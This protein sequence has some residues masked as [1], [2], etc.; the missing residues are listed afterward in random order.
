M[1]KKPPIRSARARKPSGNRQPRTSTKL[2]SP[3][4]EA[5]TVFSKAIE[6]H[7]TGR[8]AEAEALYRQ[9]FKAQP[10]HFDSL[11]LLGVFCHQ[12]GD[13]AEAL[14]HIDAA[15][16]LNPN[17]AAAHNNRGN[18]LRRLNRHEEAIVCLD[19]A[20]A[21][22]PDYAEAF[23]NRGNALQE[24]SRLDEALASFDRAIALKSDFAEAFNNRG[25]ALARLARFEEAVASYDRAIVLQPHYSEAYNNRSKALAKLARIEEAIAGYDRAIALKPDYA[26]AFNS[27]GIALAELKRFDEALASF[28]NAL[29]LKPDYIDALNN[30]GNVLRE[31]KR[32]DEALVSFEQAIALKPD[33]AEAFHNRGSALVELKQFD[34]AVASY[35]RAIVL[36]PDYIDALNSRGVALRELKRSDDA[37]ASYDRAI[38]LKPD[39]ADAFSNRG[40]ALQDLKRL[41]EAIASYDRALALKPDHADAW[42]NRGNALQ[43]LRRLDEAIA[44][45]DRAIALKS[46]YAEAFYNRGIALAELKQFDAAVASYDRAIALKPDYGEAFS[47]RGG[48]LRVLKRPAEAVASYERAIALKPNQNYLEGAWLHTKMQ[49]CDWGNYEGDCAHLVS[50]VAG[51]VA[52][53]SP[54]EFLASVSDPAAERT[55]AELF[56]AD[57]YPSAAVPLWRGERYTHDRIRVAYLSADFLEHATAYLMAGLFEAH[58]RSRFET[59]AVSFGSDKN[60]STRQRLIRSFDRFIDVRTQSDQ[61]IAELVRS[62]EVDIAV[63]LKGFTQDARTGVFAKRPA[64]IQ[65]NYLGYPGTMGADFIDYIIADKIVLPLDQEASYTEKI[66]HLPDCYQV[67]DS[68][69]RIAERTPTRAEAGLP[70]RGFV[71]CCFNNNFKITPPMFDVWMRLLRAI[72]GSVLWLLEDNPKARENLCK[73]AAARDV[74]PVRLVFARRVKVEEHLARHRLADLFLDTLPYN[75]HTTASDALWAGL[76]IVTCSGKSFPGRVAVSLL[77]AVDL[78]ELVTHTLAD[79]EALAV[80][81]ATEPRLL[82]A[83]KEKLARNRLTAPLF[84]TERFRRHIEAAYTTM[85][86]IWQRREAPRSLSIE[87]DR[88]DQRGSDTR[89]TAA[90]VVSAR[91]NYSGCPLCDSRQMKLFA[92]GDCSRH[93][94]SRPELPAV[95]RWLRCEA[96]GH[97]FTEGYHTSDA[98]RV[99]FGKTS[100]NQKVGHDVERQRLVSA[101]IVEKVAR[102]VPD[103]CWLDVGFGNG[104]LI[105]TA[106]EWGY[107]AVGI[108]L[109]EDNVEAV[110]KLGFQAHCVEISQVDQAGQFSVVSMADV[111][112]HMPFP[113]VGLAA[114]HRLLR[115]G[116]ALFVSMPNRDSVVWRFLDQSKANPYWGEVEHYHNFGRVRLSR[117]LAEHGFKVVEYGVSERYRACME[118]IAI[119]ES[120]S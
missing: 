62:L 58:D 87:A 23:N 92:Q 18:A 17:A 68:K 40:N 111:L 65:V 99:I 3:K 104:S 24:L 25:S 84:D 113:K 100:D 71:F 47:N 53:S 59:I 13:Y 45:Y 117:L 115:S 48:A 42:S 8:L 11:H 95:M 112:E 31:L 110:R 38:Q 75:A 94:L 4:S 103:G 80:K 7:R 21:L 106:D 28:S 37:L 85:W 27:R 102:H 86:E 12:R 91:V 56:V 69:R 78:P 70:E 119:R 96:C 10:E 35:D 9:I 105:F 120:H 26:E 34:A 57:K 30:R 73:E 49:I 74:N 72:D 1:K 16:E 64:P 93:S 101:R 83:I 33:Y 46:N 2:A 20:I 98:L 63:D 114:A 76:P 44:S 32:V 6:L 89:V 82:D 43:E 107:S 5:A 79:F 109:R 66:V 41:D 60:S 90:P 116:G 97:I 29:A 55:C 22:K 15:L 14:R 81:L 36:K 54:F 19:R 50:A 52:A 61:A 51:G 88:L 108:D 39:Q 77:N 67:N 118:M